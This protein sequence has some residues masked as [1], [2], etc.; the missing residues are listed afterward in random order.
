MR[1]VTACV[2]S[3]LLIALAGRGDAQDAPWCPAPVEGHASPPAPAAPHPVAPS[4]LLP[5]PS[6]AR[7]VA[8]VQPGGR[9]TPRVA[10]VKPAPAPPKPP[11]PPAHGGARSGPSR[12]AVPVT[13]QFVGHLDDGTQ[14]RG[15]Q[16]EGVRV[17]DVEIVVH[18]SY[19][20]QSHTQRVLLYSPDGNLYQTRMTAVSPMDQHTE[21]PS[22]VTTPLPV[23]GSWISNFGL[24]GT[25]RVEVYLDE[26][27]DP[28]LA[29]TFI[30]SRPN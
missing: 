14:Q 1:R 27:T 16:F 28:S 15:V 20:E 26:D 22:V 12:Y 7:G 3:L 9:I 2:V 5:P 13:M 10:V 30:L 21:L 24:Y 4:H 8:P 19:L 6:A 23:A 17:N 29:Q 18:W 11:A 25:W